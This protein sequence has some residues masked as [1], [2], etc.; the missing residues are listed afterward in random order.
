MLI[1]SHK[2]EAQAPARKRTKT[3][4]AVLLLTSLMCF[5]ST[6]VELGVV[7][8]ADN[9]PTDQKQSETQKAME[10]GDVLRAKWTKDS[11]REAITQY[12]NAVFI[13]TSASDFASASQ[14][15]LKCGDVYLLFSE[16]AAALARKTGDWLMKA[17]ALSRMGRLQSFVGNNELAQQQ[18]TEALHLFKEHE[19][20]QSGIVANAYGEALS[21]LA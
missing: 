10:R 4:T 17:N 18:L 21:N 15:T 19:P 16:Y 8:S 6:F 7:S 14:A 9:A 3:K 12:E 5:C 11:L 13:A 1:F 20:N 2:T